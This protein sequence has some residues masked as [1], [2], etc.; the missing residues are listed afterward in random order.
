MEFKKYISFCNSFYVKVHC[1][2]S[3]HILVFFL[4]CFWLWLMYWFYLVSIF[5]LVYIHFFNLQKC[6]SDYQHQV[7]L[8][9][10]FVL[11]VYCGDYC[12]DLSRNFFINVD[13]PENKHLLYGCV[14]FHYNDFY[15]FRFSLIGILSSNVWYNSLKTHTVVFILFIFYFFC[16]LWM[17]NRG[18]FKFFLHLQW[19][20]SHYI[21]SS[22]ISKNNYGLLTNTI[23]CN[24][25]FLL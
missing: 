22:T 13:K 11:L 1:T 5:F 12:F 16:S 17:I 4:F 2:A 23:L 6:K 7:Y 24:D 21:Q 20:I 9:M 25:V 10:N 18:F 14:L 3:L 15:Q 8:L 19:F